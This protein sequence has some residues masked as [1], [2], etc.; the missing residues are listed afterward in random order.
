[1][2]FDLTVMVVVRRAVHVDLG[3]AGFAAA[4][5]GTLCSQQNRT[6][7]LLRLKKKDGAL[8]VPC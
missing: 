7:S 2:Q 5:P 8:H 1:M 3:R 6:V 4:R